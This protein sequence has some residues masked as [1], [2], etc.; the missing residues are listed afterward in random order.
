MSLEAMGSCLVVGTT[1]KLVFE[2]YMERVLAP[3]PQLEQGMILD[4][5]LAHRESVRE[6]IEKRG[7]SLLYLP[8]YSPDFSS[9][10]ESF[11]KVR[12]LLR[13]AKARTRVALV[14]AIGHA[15]GRD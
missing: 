12:A 15:P 4:N 14:E 9:I 3:S 7:C 2:V 6:L 1:T 13:K 5:L 10:E 8:P 11:S